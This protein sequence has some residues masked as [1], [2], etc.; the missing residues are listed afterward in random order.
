MIDIAKKAFGILGLILAIGYA[1]DLI[2]YWPHSGN[3]SFYVIKLIAYIVGSAS[4]FWLIFFKD[5]FTSIG[6]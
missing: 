3:D 5:K 4:V 1:I 6:K 2:F